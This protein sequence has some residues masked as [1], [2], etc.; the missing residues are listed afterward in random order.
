MAPHKCQCRNSLSIK[1]AQLCDSLVTLLNRLCLNCSNN[2]CKIYRTHWFVVLFDDFIGIA[3]THSDDGLFG[4]GYRFFNIGFLLH[5]R[6]FSV[7][8]I[9]NLFDLLLLLLNKILLD[10]QL[11]QWENCEIPR[12]TGI[13]IKREG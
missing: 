9:F 6:F 11:I 5:G 13:R 12:N 8:V 7:W 3:N 10:I 1:I 2:L 4:W